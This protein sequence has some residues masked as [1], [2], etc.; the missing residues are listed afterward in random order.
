MGL[1]DSE[2]NGTLQDGAVSVY[3]GVLGDGCNGAAGDALGGGGGI[4]EQKVGVGKAG[5]EV[6]HCGVARCV[7]D[8]EGHTMH[9]DAL[10]W[11]D[12]RN[13]AACAGGQ[14]GQ[15]CDGQT[16]AKDIFEKT[17]PIK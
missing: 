8:R 3:A 6:A 5:F 13:H 9:G 1:L 14:S 17:L 7:G 10:T 16:T 2:L 12:V 15:R 4:R 11:H